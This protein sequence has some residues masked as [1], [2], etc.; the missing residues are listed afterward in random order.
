LIDDEQS[1]EVWR[2]Q[3]FFFFVLTVRNSPVQDRR[4]CHSLDDAVV[5]AAR[6]CIATDKRTLS[7][8]DISV[9]VHSA[10][11]GKSITKLLKIVT[12]GLE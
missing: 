7:T 5:H 11:S 10:E 3:T 9:V 8:S 6:R 12:K 4:E 1:T 2:L